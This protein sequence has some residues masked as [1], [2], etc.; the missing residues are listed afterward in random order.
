MKIKSIS[1]HYSGKVEVSIGDKKCRI[2][3]VINSDTTSTYKLNS[4]I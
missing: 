3:N 4:V 2:I 1:Q